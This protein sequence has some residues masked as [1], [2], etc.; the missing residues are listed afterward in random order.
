MA[1]GFKV[2]AQKTWWQ[3]NST[4]IWRLASITMFLGL[5]SWTLV[6]ITEIP[7]KYV[8]KTDFVWAIDKIEKKIDG[9]NNNFGKKFDKINDNLIEIA[10]NEGNPARRDPG[11]G[12]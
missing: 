5:A 8:C 12:G 9:M 1:N 10:R 11:S 3:G 7:D 4:R 6:R 2:E